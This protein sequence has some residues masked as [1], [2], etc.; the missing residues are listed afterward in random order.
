METKS[1]PIKKPVAIPPEKPLDQETLDMIFY[2]AYRLI[3]S[4][5]SD[6]IAEDHQSQETYGISDR[7]V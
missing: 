6:H 3:L 1:L 2:K 5:P 7:S 4:W